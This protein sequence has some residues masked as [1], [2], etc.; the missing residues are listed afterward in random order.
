[1]GN[2]ARFRFVKFSI[3]MP[4]VGGGK[5]FW[6][7]L[8]TNRQA[9]RKTTTTNNNALA[10]QSRCLLPDVFQQQCRT[11]LN[12]VNLEHRKT[13]THTEREHVCEAAALEF[14]QSKVAF[15]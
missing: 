9:G 8:N 15:F 6:E 4:S 3:L 7:T 14:S 11:A 10:F 5:S 13:H 1:M 2:A 12:A